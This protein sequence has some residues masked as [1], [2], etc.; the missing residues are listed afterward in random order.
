M[1][2]FYF[3]EEGLDYKIIVKLFYFHQY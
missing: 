3:Y 2:F 1:H